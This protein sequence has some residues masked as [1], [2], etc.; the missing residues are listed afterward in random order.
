[1]VEVLRQ[2]QGQP[3]ES[4]SVSS[5][6]LVEVL[7]V[8]RIRF[9]QVVGH[10]PNNCGTDVMAVVLRVVGKSARV[11]AVVLEEMNPPCHVLLSGRP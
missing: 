11:Q 5:A 3:W 2:H 9:L 1:M 7:G 10:Q 4:R 8:E 6:I